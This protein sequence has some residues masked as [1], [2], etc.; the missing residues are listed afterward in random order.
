MSTTRRFPT[1]I[2]VDGT[3]PHYNLSGWYDASRINYHQIR[4]FHVAF[5][6]SL[7]NTRITLGGRLASLYTEWDSHAWHKINSAKFMDELP[8][9]CDSIIMGRECH[10]WWTSLH[11]IWP[12]FLWNKTC[13]HNLSS[14]ASAYM[15][16]HHTL[17]CVWSNTLYLPSLQW[18]VVHISGMLHRDIHIQGLFS[19]IPLASLN[20]SRWLDRNSRYAAT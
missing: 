16:W 7:Q 3:M 11:V 12:G 20:G 5:P 10:N 19:F 13:D 2:W 18:I 8:H 14:A 6:W 9:I 15:Q 17:K 4:A 1:I